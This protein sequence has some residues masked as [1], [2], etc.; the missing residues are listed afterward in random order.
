MQ[1]KF[2]IINESKK[3]EDSPVGGEGGVGV[4]AGPGGDIGVGPG[5][6]GVPPPEEVHVQSTSYA[7][8]HIIL[9]ESNNVFTPHDISA[10]GC[11]PEQ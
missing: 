11:P 3:E 1:M 4:G 7:Q 9:S 5:G 6:V 10:L 2:H 8:S